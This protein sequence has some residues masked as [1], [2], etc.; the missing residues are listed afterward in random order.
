MADSKTTK[1]LL[2]LGLATLVQPDVE[3]VPEVPRVKPY[4]R[5]R[6]AS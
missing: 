1:A 5:K 2:Q 6:R 3:P 4:K